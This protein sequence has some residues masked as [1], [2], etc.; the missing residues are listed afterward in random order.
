MLREPLLSLRQWFSTCWDTLREHPC[1]PRPDGAT[2]PGVWRLKKTEPDA[3]PLHGLHAGCCAWSTDC[4]MTS[5]GS[6]IWGP[7]FLKAFSL[8][9][10]SHSMS[11]AATCFLTVWN[12]HTGQCQPSW[13]VLA[14]ER[15]WDAEKQT[16]SSRV[17]RAKLLWKHADFSYVIILARLLPYSL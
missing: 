3:A 4:T 1:V 2:A 7:F 13:Q 16:G 15:D 14:R 10:K 12:H 17:F 5:G 8:L 11:F 6:L 9:L